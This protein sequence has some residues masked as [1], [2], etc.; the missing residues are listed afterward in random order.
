MY[1]VSGMKKRIS[2]GKKAVVFIWNILTYMRYY[3]HKRQRLYPTLL[4]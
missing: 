2:V 3:E 1:N 4:G